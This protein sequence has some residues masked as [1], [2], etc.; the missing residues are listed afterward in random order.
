MEF[1]P[2][3]NAHSPRH[4]H[5]SDALEGTCHDGCPTMDVIERGRRIKREDFYCNRQRRKIAPQEGCPF[6]GDD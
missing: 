1:Q 5:T 4:P 2:G 3:Y 6:G